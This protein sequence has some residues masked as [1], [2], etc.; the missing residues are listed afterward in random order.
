MSRRIAL[1]ILLLLS[2]GAYS[3]IVASSKGSADADSPRFEERVKVRGRAYTRVGLTVTV[4]DRSGRTV[5]GLAR[6]EFHL[7]QDGVE[8]PIQELFVEGEQT[9]RPLSVA[10]LLD[11]SESMSQQVQRV[12]EAAK[13]L[14]GALRAGDEI[15]VA[16]FNQDR[17]VLQPFTHD[18]GD[19]DQ[20]LREIGKAEGGTAL[21]R[22]IEETLKDLRTRP[23]RKVILVVT[24]GLD[25][26]VGRD[27]EVLLSQTMQDLLHL[28]LRTQTIV[29]GIRPGM[30][31]GRPPF[32]RFVEETGGRLLY[33]S[34]DLG[35]LFGQLGTE[36]LGQYHLGYDID[37]EVK[38]GRRR[39]IR[40]EVSRPDLTVKTMA[41]YFTPRSQLETLLR[42][43]K[44]EDARLRADAA[45]EL[46]FVSEPRSS[47]ALRKALHDKDEK[48][49]ELAAGAL[50]RLGDE[51]AIPDLM[52][53]LGDK[54][55]TATVRGS[56]LR[57]LAALWGQA[58][59]PRLEEYL[60]SETD[61]GL[62]EMART[63]LSSL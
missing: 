7:F 48:V 49:R 17:V 45:Y 9:D 31:T 2:L 39:S 29:Y 15:M 27:R 5:Q 52:K 1:L 41:G 34:D 30:V 37:P 61:P 25:N 40:V 18:P 60:Q 32:E 19:P 44:D 62:K 22:S 47:K 35:R 43:I 46:G 63:L 10:V 6:E 51:E 16:R 11:L 28:C 14:L 20:T 58:S 42:D 26:G 54:K 23:G 4:M 13:A 33:T 53:L 56:A 55:E 57:S 50:A 59:R 12:R 21:F 36:L 38:Q 24:D 8:M 3:T